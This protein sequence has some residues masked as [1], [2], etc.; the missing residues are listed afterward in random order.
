MILYK[1]DNALC[2]KNCNISD[3]VT[4]KGYTGLSGGVLLPDKYQEKH[5]CNGECFE[6]WLIIEAN[7]CKKEIVGAL[8]RKHKAKS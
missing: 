6:T 1:C 8:N 5:F 7:I 2:D 3:M 4:L